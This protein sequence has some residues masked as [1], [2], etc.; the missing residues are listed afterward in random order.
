MS[1][2][3]WSRPDLI[4]LELGFDRFLKGFRVSGLGFGLREKIVQVLVRGF[5]KNRC[6]S[7]VRV[8][9]GVEVHGF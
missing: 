7:S 8:L 5:S 1:H 9:E 6:K 3:C 4:S 2:L